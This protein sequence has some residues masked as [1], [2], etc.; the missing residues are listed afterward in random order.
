VG[1]RGAVP[2][3]SD[4]RRRR[5]ADG[6][7]E[8]VSFSGGAVEAPALRAGLH[9]LAASWY[10]SLAISGQSRYYEPSD[11]MMAQIIAEAIDV[12]AVSRKSTTLSQILAGSSVLL[13]TEGDRRRMRLELLRAASDEGAEDNVI[14][15]RARAT[16][17][18]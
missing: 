12:F 13:A 16:A 17:G 18:N 14:D 3:R 5:N 7:P 11:W 10:E 1:T 9:P 8:I 2:K 15:W 6:Q 4:Q